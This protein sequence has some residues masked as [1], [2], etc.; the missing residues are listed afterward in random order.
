MQKTHV[1]PVMATASAGLVAGLLVASS[2]TAA[3]AATARYEAETSPA[4][5][6]GTIDSDWTGYSGSG[7]C[8]GTNAAGAYA[9]FTVTA[10][11]SGTATLSVRFANGTTAA[12]AASVTVNGTTAATTSFE[13]TGTWTGWTTKTLTVPVTSGSNVIRINPTVATGL[14]NIDYLDAN[15]PDGGTTPPPA[16]SALYVSPSGTDGA[17]GTISNP[18]T[19]TSAISR[20][21]AGGTIYLRGGTYAH[22]S[23]VT[24]PVGNS[25]TAAA[26]TKLSA[27]PGETPVLNFSAQSES[28]SNRG[29]QINGSYWHVHG[30][31]V[32]RA[33][34][35]GIY[36]GGS[37]NVIERTVTRFNR[38]TGLQ[39]G[40]IASSTPAADWP[41]DNLILSAESHDNADSDGEDAD[42]FAA[43]LTTG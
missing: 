14:P 15:V 6:T 20:I 4:V 24:I 43:K 5:C 37:D 17:A 12:R 13:S 8:N 39:L 35:N 40:R 23:T 25:G 18:T 29:L 7:F 21:T 22:S 1:R 27:Y 16:G 19:L 31:V 30:L 42:G 28:S 34:D 2:G 41:S 36:V 26:R 10:P 3:Q 33:G 32:E 11:A 38:D 9:Q